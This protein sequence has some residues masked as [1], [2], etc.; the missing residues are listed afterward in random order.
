[1]LYYRCL[2]P[3]AVCSAVVC[4]VYFKIFNLYNQT[5]KADQKGN[6]VDERRPKL[7]VFDLGK[8]I[9]CVHSN[10]LNLQLGMSTFGRFVF[11]VQC[12]RLSCR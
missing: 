12:L 4:T 2:L 7:I 6:A 1:M 11:V 8:C 9:S 10:I 3:G 5:S